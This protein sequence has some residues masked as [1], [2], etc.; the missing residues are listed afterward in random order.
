[1][2]RQIQAASATP[3]ATPASVLTIAIS[4]SE[5]VNG[6]LFPILREG[7]ED[8]FLGV[9]RGGDTMTRRLWRLVGRVSR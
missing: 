6:P 2:D 8:N 4:T 5:V 1:M 3:S 9:M 7:L